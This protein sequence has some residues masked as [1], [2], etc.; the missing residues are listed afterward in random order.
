MKKDYILIPKA[1]FEAYKIS[2]EH[3]LNKEEVL[4]LIV[5]KDLLKKFIEQKAISIQLDIWTW[6]WEWKEALWLWVIKE[7]FSI[8]TEIWNMKEVYN[9]YK[10]DQEKKEEEQKEK[11]EEN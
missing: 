8:A 5:H 4:K 1:T 7:L 9:I 2:N 6:K 11:E 3:I 10:K